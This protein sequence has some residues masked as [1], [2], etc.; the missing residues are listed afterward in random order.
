MLLVFHFILNYSIYLLFLFLEKQSWS[1]CCRQ[2][3]KTSVWPSEVSL[4]SVLTMNVCFWMM[5][6]CMK[7]FEKHGGS[8]IWN[9]VVSF[10]FEFFYLLKHCFGSN[11]TEIGSWWV[12]K[13]HVSFSRV[14][15]DNGG[16]DFLPLHCYGYLPHM[17]NNCQKWLTES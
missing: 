9:D 17:A 1:D 5:K 10:T 3:W 12:F 8:F 15:S 16:T 11:S 13:W 6:C 2:Q 14:N 7:L 4:F